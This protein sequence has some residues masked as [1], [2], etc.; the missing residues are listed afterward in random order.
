MLEF[1]I[2]RFVVSSGRFLGAFRRGVSSGRFVEAFRRFIGAFRGGVSSGC[3]VGAFRRFVR[4]LVG[5]FVVSGG[6]S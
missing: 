1:C 5:R 4:R 3:F 6:V 2:G